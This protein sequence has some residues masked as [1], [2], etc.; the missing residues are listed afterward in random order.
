MNNHKYA[1]AA[2]DDLW[3]ALTNQSHLDGTLD[4][5][6]TVKQIMDTWTLRKGYPVV[7]VTRDLYQNKLKV[8]ITQIFLFFEKN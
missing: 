8:N 6:L 5:S 3:A 1:N 7:K 2:Q 4:K